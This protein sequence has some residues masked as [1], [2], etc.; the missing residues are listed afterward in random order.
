MAHHHGEHRAAGAVGQGGTLIPHA[1][2]GQKNV[3]LIP[4]TQRVG[5]QT[6]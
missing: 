3:R 2:Q 5:P 6:M 4:L 1:Q